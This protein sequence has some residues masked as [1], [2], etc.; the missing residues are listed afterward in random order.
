MVCCPPAPGGGGVGRF[1]PGGR[2]LLPGGD[3]IDDGKADPPGGLTGRVGGL[4]AGVVGGLFA[5]AAGA[6][7]AAGG[8]DA[9]TGG[10]GM[11]GRGKALL[12]GVG[13]ADPVAAAGGR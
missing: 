13:G 1:P 11:P 3:V 5:G 8:G 4:I 12:A 6:L 10:G 2:G 7:L 9:D